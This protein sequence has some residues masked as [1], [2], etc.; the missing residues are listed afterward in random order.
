MLI[1][2]LVK[3]SFLVDIL[4]SICLKFSENVPGMI[5]LLAVWFFYSLIVAMAQADAAHFNRKTILGY[6]QPVWS[7]GL[8]GLQP[9]S[10]G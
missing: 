10:K 8:C 1:T 9:A 5:L 6:S 3:S 7:E 4:A 2:V